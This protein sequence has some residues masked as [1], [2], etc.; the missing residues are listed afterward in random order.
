MR[1]LIALLLMAMMVLSLAACTGPKEQ[2]GDDGSDDGMAAGNDSSVEVKIG[3]FGTATMDVAVKPRYDNAIA[4]IEAAGGEVV[5]A[6]VENNDYV[7]ALE[8]LINAG[9]NGVIF[10]GVSGNGRHHRGRLYPVLPAGGRA[11]GEE[12]RA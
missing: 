1:K 7:S 3:M 8:T 5:N 4:F 2:K 12:F 11:G 9:C 10:V 6:E